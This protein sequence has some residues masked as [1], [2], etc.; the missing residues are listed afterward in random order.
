MNKYI[1]VQELNPRV[2]EEVDYSQFLVVLNFPFVFQYTSMLVYFN[3]DVIEIYWKNIPWN[4]KSSCVLSE[5]IVKWS[6]HH[7]LDY[8]H[9]LGND[10]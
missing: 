10:L 9:V 5:K 7:R 6:K 1:R 2:A 4:G 3:T 8:G